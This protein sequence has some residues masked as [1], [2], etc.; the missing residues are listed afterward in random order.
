MMVDQAGIEPAFFAYKT[1]VLN[2][3]TTGPLAI[4]G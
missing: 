4:I 2:R 1:N 3:Y